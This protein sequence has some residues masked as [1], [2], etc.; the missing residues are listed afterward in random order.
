MCT[1]LIEEKIHKM[2]DKWYPR[3]NTIINIVIKNMNTRL[4]MNSPR[5]SRHENFGGDLFFFYNIIIIIN[6]N[7]KYN[8]NINL[9]LLFS[10]IISEAHC[11][12]VREYYYH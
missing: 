7:I 2:H 3:I 1:F 5:I 4:S 10:T 8:N 12:I 6:N 11:I 9:K